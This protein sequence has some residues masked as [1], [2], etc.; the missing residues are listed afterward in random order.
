M[1]QLPRSMQMALQMLASFLR[2][3]HQQPGKEDYHQA[4]Y[5]LRG[6]LRLLVPHIERGERLRPD[7][8]V[9]LAGCALHLLAEQMH[10]EAGGRV[11]P[12]VDAQSPAEIAKG[13]T[14][15]YANGRRLHGSRPCTR[16]PVRA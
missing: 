7:Q 15:I 13:C 16:H 4:Y 1:S 8:L 3:T 10:A 6:G 5:Q 14:C 9:S 12:N 2:D 11:V